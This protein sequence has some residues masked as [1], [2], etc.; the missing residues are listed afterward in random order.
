MIISTVIETSSIGYVKPI[1]VSY[2]PFRSIY[3][4][5]RPMGVG[6]RERA[7]GREEGMGESSR[8]RGIE[9]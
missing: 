7:R 8:D 4:K 1:Y 3:F 6:G 5:F 9:K 2:G